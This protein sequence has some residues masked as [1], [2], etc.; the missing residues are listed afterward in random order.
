MKTS[1]QSSNAMQSTR[2]LQ[3]RTPARPLQS[4]FVLPALIFLL[5]FAASPTARPECRDGC[6]S[7]TG[8]TCQGEEA[9]RNNTVNSNFNTA[10]GYFALTANTGGGYNTATGS[11]ALGSNTTGVQNTA[12]GALALDINTTG[13]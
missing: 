13:S 2:A 10:L 7:S 3:R 12:V 5:S 11:L 1:D 8:N 9:L 4:L 6:D